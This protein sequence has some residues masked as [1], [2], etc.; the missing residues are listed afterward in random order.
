[1][2]AG[3]GGQAAGSDAL[4]SATARMSKGTKRRR[5]TQARISSMCGVVQV[6]SFV[7]LRDA[8]KSATVQVRT[9][10]RS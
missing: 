2:E 7:R 1:M 10:K 3:R 4:Q 8:L 6:G 5:S 9:V